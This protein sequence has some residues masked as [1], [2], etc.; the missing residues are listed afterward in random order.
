MESYNDF[1]DRL[2]AR[3]VD[4]KDLIIEEFITGKLYSVD[5]FVSSEGEVRISKPVKVKL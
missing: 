3:G 4:N 2:K 1:H 5:Y